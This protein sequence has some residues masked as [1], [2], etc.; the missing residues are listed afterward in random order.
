MRC[1]DM[2][3]AQS[4][5]IRAIILNPSVIIGPGSALIAKLLAYLRWMPICPML[6]NINSFVDVRD[7]T[8]AAVLS[9]SHGRS[10]ERYIVTT[11]NVDQLTLLRAIVHIMHKRSPVIPISDGWL[12]R[13]DILLALVSSLGLNPGLRPAENYTVDKQFS[14]Q[15]INLEMGWQPDYT[16]EESLQYV[17]Q[18]DMGAGKRESRWPYRLAH[19]RFYGARP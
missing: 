8:K 3:R 12:H 10:G 7:V 5:R 1:E 18:A 15:K 6:A 14:A 13:Y 2:L 17:L 9:L 11:T 4:Y 19:R 16:L